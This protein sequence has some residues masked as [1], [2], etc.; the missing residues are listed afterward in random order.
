MKCNCLLEMRIHIPVIKASTNSRLFCFSTKSVVILE[1]LA[2]A[3]EDAL[4]RECRVVRP[5][6]S[7]T[8]NP[9]YKAVSP[10][11]R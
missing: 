8:Q 5:A 3:Q 9:T 2:E 10:P 4:V 6:C 1:D 7:G 11:N